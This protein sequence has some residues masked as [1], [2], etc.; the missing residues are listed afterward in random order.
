MKSVR[1]KLNRKSIREIL[2][3][4]DVRADLERRAQAIADAAGGGEDYE[5]SSQVGKNR[6]RASVITATYE[7]RAAEAKDRTLST[8]IEAGRA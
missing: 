5:V 7:A 3:S 1:I 4:D 8:A 6:A 2:Q